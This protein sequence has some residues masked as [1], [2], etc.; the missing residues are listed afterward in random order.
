VLEGV[1]DG[2]EHI[3]DRVGSMDV[4]G[5]GEPVPPRLL[6][7]QSQI[8]PTVL[9]VKRTGAG[10]HV[11]AAGHHLHHVTAALGSF[12]DR[13]P[14]RVGPFGLAAEEVAVAAAGGDRRARGDDLTCVYTSMVMLIC[15]WPR[16]SITTRG[17]TPAAVRRVAVPWR[18]S[19]R[20]ITR[21]P[22]DWATRVKERYRLRG[23]TGRPVR[24][25]KLCTD[26][27]YKL[28]TPKTW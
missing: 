13:G 5:R 27:R 20:R 14:Q 22:A 17:A 26:V 21:R 11:A 9:P 3:P 4:R 23:S 1:E 2:A 28:V 25:A 16:I 19:C 8:G 10:R 6:D 18:A 24:V 15:E 7:D 12:A